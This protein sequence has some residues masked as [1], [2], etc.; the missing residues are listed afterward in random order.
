MFQTHNRVVADVPGRDDPMDE[1][2]CSLTGRSL[3]IIIIP[4]KAT[5]QQYDFFNMAGKGCIG[6]IHPS[7]NAV[8]VDPVDAESR[9]AQLKATR[10]IVHHMIRFFHLRD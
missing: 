9:P 5:I 2:I 3:H 8:G 7:L 1:A 4:N 10:E 6:E